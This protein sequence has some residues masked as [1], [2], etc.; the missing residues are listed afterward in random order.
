MTSSIETILLKKQ[1]PGS[2][3]NASNLIEFEALLVAGILLA[4]FSGCAK[5]TAPADIF[6]PATPGAFTLLGGGDGETHF[7]WARNAEPD[8]AQYKI[9]RSVA[10]PDSFRQIIALQQTEYVDRFLEYETTYFYYITALDFAGNESAPSQI[11][12]VQPLNISSPAPPGNFA[13]SGR[14]NP[15]QS[16]VEIVLNWT[17]PNISD[18]A[19]F[20]IYRG[21]TS[22]FNIGASTLLDSSSTSA[23]RD[24]NVRPGDLFFYKVTAVDRGGKTSMPSNLNSDRI[25]FEAMLI[26]PGNRTKFAS[27]FVFSWQAVEHAEAYQVFVGR[28]PMSG[29]IWSSKTINTEILYNGPPLSANTIYYWWVGAFS[30]IS[31]AEANSFSEVRAFFVE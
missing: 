14:N 13:V 21:A 22:E 26:T 16:R 2:I 27:P 23:Y 18:V 15:A 24:Q 4:F 10:A 6:P 12:N 9:Y 1:R 29:I 7:R 25:L 31:A 17:P 19:Q 30:K 20:R 5:I 28:G 8:F 11:V 3:W